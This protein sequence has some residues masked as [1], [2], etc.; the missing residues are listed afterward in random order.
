[1]SKSIYILGGGLSG[2]YAKLQNPGAILI[3]KD[4]NITIS[5]RLINIIGG[6]DRSYAYKPRDIDLK[7]NVKDIDFGNRNIITDNGKHGYDKLIIALGHTQRTDNIKGY[8]NIAKLETIDDAI[9]IHNRLKNVKDVTIIGAGYL[10]VEL[11]SL[12]RGKKVAIID[13][14]ARILNH[15]SPEAS[16]CVYK[17]LKANNAN[18]LTGTN[19]IEVKET[20]VITGKEE[21]KSDLTIYAGGISGNSLI[22]NLSI[23][24]TNSRIRVDNKLRSL[25]YDDV[26]ACGDSMSID[27]KSFPVTAFTARKSAV[28]AMKNAMGNNIEFNYENKGNILNID[29]NYILVRENGYKRGFV[30]NTIKKYVNGKTE[31]SLNKLAKLKR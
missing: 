17:M 22:S 25:A 15:A 2:I 4:D 10:G 24:N 18:I 6:M 30:V 26:F 23:E 8:K 13:P 9:N 1:M 5:T 29:N 12:M 31:K 19:V 14:H 27:G 28:I 7:E 3:D 11:A 21:I 16:G 20:S